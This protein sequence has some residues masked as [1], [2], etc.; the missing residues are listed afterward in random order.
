[1]PEAPKEN[2]TSKVKRNGTGR[3]RI[4]A[5]MR[6]GMDLELDRLAAEDGMNKSQV[7]QKILCKEIARRRRTQSGN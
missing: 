5:S 1:M 3:I 4:S 7:L 6:P 2:P